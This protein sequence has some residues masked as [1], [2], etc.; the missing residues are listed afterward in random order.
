MAY[1]AKPNQKNNSLSVVIL[2]CIGV[3]YLRGY[4]INISDDDHFHWKCWFCVLEASK[5]FSWIMHILY[6]KSV[7]QYI[8]ILIAICVLII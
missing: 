1:Y 8:Y 6:C 2:F 7:K 5:E 4:L 3:L